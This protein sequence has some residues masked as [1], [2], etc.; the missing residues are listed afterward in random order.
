MKGNGEDGEILYYKRQESGVNMSG[1]WPLH[2]LWNNLTN[3]HDKSYENLT[4]SHFAIAPTCWR[5]EF[6]RLQ[7]HSIYC[8]FND[9][10][11]NSGY[12]AFSRRQSITELEMAWQKFWVTT[13]TIDRRDG[14]RVRT[15]QVVVAV[16]HTNGSLNYVIIRL[17][18]CYDEPM[19]NTSLRS[20]GLLCFHYQ[21]AQVWTGNCS[22][23]DTTYHPRRRE[24]STTQPWEHH[25][26]II[27]ITYITYIARRTRE[28]I[29][30]RY[31]A[32]SRKVAGS[33]P[34][35]VIGIFH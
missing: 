13:A 4:S 7:H 24:S 20:E 9:P 1:V 31:W 22:P 8:L 33:I 11:S 32:T 28:R 6:R 15:L 3:C 2:T 23:I 27:Y 19:G 29:R 25:I 26:P 30:L 5:P 12:T 17:L 14:G 10:V 18:G 35:G 16:E 34:D 21:Q